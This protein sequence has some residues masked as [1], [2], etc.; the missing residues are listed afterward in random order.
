[1]KHLDKIIPLAWLVVV[2]SFFIP[3]SESK[4]QDSI[5]VGTTKLT[6]SDE[7]YNVDVIL[8]D[9]KHALVTDGRVTIDQ[10]FGSDPQATTYFFIGTETD[11]DGVGLA[12]DTVTITIPAANSPLDL[13]YP[14]VLSITTVTPASIT[15]KTPTTKGD[16]AK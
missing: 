12:G 15:I 9:G 5:A 13:I 7:L 2:A 1:M 10:I 4:S 8:R 14:A 16:Q 11:A 3:A 6:G